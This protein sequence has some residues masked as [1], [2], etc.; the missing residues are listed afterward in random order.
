MASWRWPE[1]SAVMPVT[2]ARYKKGDM[3]KR[4]SQ[5]F[6]FAF[7]QVSLVRHSSRAPILLND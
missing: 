4:A 1:L 2:F 3:N 5:P 6:M 7:S